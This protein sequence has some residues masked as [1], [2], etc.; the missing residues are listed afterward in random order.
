MNQRIPP[1]LLV[2]LLGHG[3]L[4][5]EESA[6]TVLRMRPTHEELENRRAEAARKEKPLD[7]M[8]AEPAMAKPRKRKAASL[9]ERSTVIGYDGYWTIVPKG[10]VLYIP[11][12]LKP[13]V[14]GKPSGRLLTWED[15]FARNRGWMARQAVDIS[16]ARG[17]EELP[18]DV[19]THFRKG[20]Q[21]VVATCHNGPISMK[22]A[23][24]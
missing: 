5:G 3:S 9:V 24:K 13:R 22:K 10:A 23:S 19:I 7:W 2:A 6:T 8:E 17:E 1:L 21:I 4:Y 12:S 15:F 11:A 20:S 16:H 14:G 18:E